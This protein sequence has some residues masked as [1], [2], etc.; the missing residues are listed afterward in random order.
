MKNKEEILK[1]RMTPE[2]FKNALEMERQEER[3]RILEIIDSCN[4]GAYEFDG[5]KLVYEYIDRVKLKQKIS[6]L[7]NDN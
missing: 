3:K 7:K 2:S 1:I 6:E 5:E 4:R